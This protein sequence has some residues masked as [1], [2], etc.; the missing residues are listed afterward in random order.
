MKISISLNQKK[1]PGLP[2]VYYTD[3]KPQRKAFR[4]SSKETKFSDA[5]NSVC[6]TD[7]LTVTTGGVVRLHGDS[8]DITR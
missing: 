7:R 5:Q 1:V 6:V 4:R 2:G 8:G 3:V